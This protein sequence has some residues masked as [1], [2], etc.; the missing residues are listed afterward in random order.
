MIDESIPFVKT[1]LSGEEKKGGAPDP[2]N[3]DNASA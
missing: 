2:N 1:V 3:D